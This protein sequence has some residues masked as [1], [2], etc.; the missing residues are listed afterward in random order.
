MTVE[1]TF[2]ESVRNLTLVIELDQHGHRNLSF[3]RIK[4][5]QDGDEFSIIS[6]PGYF[7]I[8]S[9]YGTFMFGGEEDMFDFF[10]QD[11][12]KPS[13]WVEKLKPT[14]LHNGACE[15]NYNYLWSCHAILWGIKKYYETVGEGK[16]FYIQDTRDFIGNDLVWWAKGG[17]YTAHLDKA[18][19]F[20]LQEAKR[21]CSDRKTDRMWPR[22]YIDINSVKVVDSQYVLY[23]DCQADTF[24]VSFD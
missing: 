1:K 13:S 17:G 5:T 12:I 2:Q 6:G 3:K 21:I 23:R 20:N 24:A 10:F 11:E 18:E 19:L 9:D 8:S 15:V 7:C 4:G 22:E 14:N 16:L